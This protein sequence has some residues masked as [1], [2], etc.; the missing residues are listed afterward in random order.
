VGRGFY[1][2]IEVSVGHK[3]R[4]MRSILGHKLARLKDS[5]GPN[6]KKKS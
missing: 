2:I 5:G 4:R 6:Q 3:T 1:K